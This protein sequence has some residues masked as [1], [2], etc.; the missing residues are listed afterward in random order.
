[1]PKRSLNHPQNFEQ[2]NQAIE[3]LLAGKNDDAGAYMGNA[4][5]APLARIAVELRHLPRPSFKANLKAEI[6]R[7]AIMPATA[8]PTTKTRTSVAP[9]IPFRDAA[10]AIE[11]YER[12]FG[13]KE[14]E[15]FQIGSSIPHAELAIGDSVILITEEW[16]EGGRYSA[17]TWGH[18]P[19]LMSLQVP[20]VDAFVDHAVEEGA[21]LILPPR[22][23]FY[24][25]RDAT[26][27][28]P[29]GYTWSISTVKEEMTVEEMHR[30]FRASSPEQQ[31]P[32][33]S[34]VSPVPKGYDTVT[35][36]L[37]ARD[38]EGLVNFAKQAFGAEEQFRMVGEAGSLHCEVKI[39]DSVV[40][41][42]GGIPGREFKG[43]PNTTAIHMYVEDSDAAYERALA[44]G[45]TSIDPPRDQDYGERSSTVKDPAGNMW[46]MATAFGENYLPQELHNV[47]VYLHPLRA[48]PLIRF[49]QQAFGAREMV[50]YVSPD[51]V[52]NHAALQVGSS[53]IEMGEAHG[54]YQ[55]M[56]SMFYLY[57][58]DCDMVYRKAL[59]AGAAS[60]YEPR[61][62]PY[63]DRN[64]AVKDV[65]GNQWYIATHIGEPAKK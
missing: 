51:G 19:I 49:I 27:L 61:D 43:T 41:I 23:Q 22:D 62:Q 4:E 17:E 7:S 14:I 26:V 30:R 65:F 12:A 47:N 10:K 31:R 63:G 37:M 34:R 33:A 2:L 11:F 40:M 58:P 1:M 25:R 48:E 57:V 53:A 20:D 55:P 9:R 6:E 64:G 29:F 50:K 3:A 56:T 15:R 44:A 21:K 42:G 18:S 13:A 32:E 59:A 46:Y 39:G 38:A 28:D 45:A 16:P 52:V 54:P 60:V 36:Y 5:I 35:P 24:G 8:E